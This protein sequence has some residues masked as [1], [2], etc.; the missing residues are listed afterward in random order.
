M[1][2]KESYI[3]TDDGVRL[4]VR[5]IGSGVSPVL[6]VPNAVWL[7]DDFAKL[8]D[9]RKVVFYDLRNRGHSDAVIDSAKLKHGVH[10]DVDDLEAVRKH[11]GAEQI[12][13]LG[14]SYLGVMVIL[15]AMKYPERVRRA[16]QIGAAPPDFSKQYPAHL[17]GDD[18]TTQ[19]TRAKLAHLQ[20]TSSPAELANPDGEWATLFRSLFVVNAK[21]AA[22]VGAAAKY[23]PNERTAMKHIGENVMPSLFKLRLNQDQLAAVRATVLTIHGT[24]DRQAP[25]GGGIDWATLLPSA[26]L[27]TVHDAAHLPW[28]EAPDKVLRAIDTFLKGEW[29]AEAEPKHPA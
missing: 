6:V 17:T 12:D 23:V 25:Y 20:A 24:R 18:A 11:I 7:L 15:Y 19:E 21:D 3:T 14:H 10:H 27:L 29:P 16:V 1:N 9:Q 26:R 4:F 13:V 2:I 5:Q 28:I 8:G 22:R